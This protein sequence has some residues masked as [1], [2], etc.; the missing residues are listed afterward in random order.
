MRKNF[1]KISQSMQIGS[2]LLKY[3]LW[4]KRF[5]LMA[6]L[7]LTNRCNLKCIYCYPQVFR[8]NLDDM[9]TDK[10]L[11]ITDE[12]YKMGARVIV[13]MGGEPLLFK[14]IDVIVDRVKSYGIICE[15]ITNGYLIEKKID[16]VK[17]L[18]S[19]CISLD[20]NEATH[21]RN[22]GKGS[23][24]K[25][26][27][28]IKCA[29]SAAIRTRVK[30]V[31]IRHNVN[32]LRFLAQFAKEHGVVLTFTLPSI[33]TD[34]EDLTLTHEEIKELM[35]MAIEYKR[36]GYPIGHTLTSMD[37]MM[38]WPANHYAWLD[39]KHCAGA[40]V[41]RCIRNDLTCYVDADGMMYPCAI[42]WSQFPG[43]NVFEA[44]IK[45]AWN[46]LAQK[47]CYSCGYLGEIETNLLLSLSIRNIFQ[48]ARYFLF[49]S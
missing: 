7:L 45:D 27:A 44:G 43:K 42:L 41:V 35:T 30:A 31:I 18:D 10:W 37:Y 29:K 16:T 8:R 40:P 23:Y 4:R 49:G 17:K 15:M 47:P 2:M 25:A 21:D 14:D 38:K 19:I 34:A 20:G 48:S 39:E 33:H 28:A 6:N 3:K 1:H 11:K 24:Q 32:S 5:P 22:R 46:N 26:V 13:L 9:T 12:L 36:E